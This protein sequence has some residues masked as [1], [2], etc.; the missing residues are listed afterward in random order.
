MIAHPAANITAALSLFAPL[1]A[2]A[3]TVERVDVASAADALSGAAITRAQMDGITADI[4][5]RLAQG[6]HTTLVTLTA[7][8]GTIA[9]AILASDSLAYDASMPLVA[10]YSF[11]RA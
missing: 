7:A 6:A 3:D 5:A 1:Q 2:L 8:D 9:G 11:A 10:A 4:L